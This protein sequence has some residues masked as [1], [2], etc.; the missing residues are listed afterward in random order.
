MKDQDNIASGFNGVLRKGSRPALLV[1]DYQRAFTE[2]DLSPLASPSESQL[3]STNRLIDAMRGLGP[4]LFTIVAYED[5]GRD[6]GLWLQKN[7]GLA[8]LRRGSPQSTLDPRLNYDPGQDVVIYKTQASAFFGTPLA[9]LLARDGIDMLIVAGVTTSG[10]V[11]ASVVDALQN[12]FA[13]FVVEEAIGDRSAAQH[14]S[15]LIDMQSKYAE[16]VSLAE[17]LEHLGTLQSAE[18]T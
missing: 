10:C 13:P 18:S 5:N 8:A 15:N 1:I 6:A 14:H 12:G 9:A 11:R 3:E 16:V 4:V 7:P 2:T 17:A